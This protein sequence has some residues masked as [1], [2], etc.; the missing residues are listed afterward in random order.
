MEL[1]LCLPATRG[2][3]GVMRIKAPVIDDRSD[4]S[5]KF[6][7]VS[8]EV[9]AEELTAVIVFVLDRVIM[10]AVMS[11]FMVVHI[12]VAIYIGF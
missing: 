11:L 4:I 10:Y 12:I 1:A 3:Y 9:N 8:A 2:R 7:L 6:K 5:E